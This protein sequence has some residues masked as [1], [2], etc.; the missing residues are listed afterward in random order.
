M[1][2]ARGKNTASCNNVAPNSL[3]TLFIWRLS[4]LLGNKTWNKKLISTFLWL[5]W[6]GLAGVGSWTSCWPGW[7]WVQWP[8]PVLSSLEATGKDY[9][10]SNPSESSSTS[11]WSSKTSPRRPRW[12]AVAEIY[13]WCGTC[14]RL[15]VV[16]RVPFRP[17]RNVP[18]ARETEVWRGL[19]ERRHATRECGRVL[20]SCRCERRPPPSLSTRFRSCV[21]GRRPA[22]TTRSELTYR[23]CLSS[24]VP[25]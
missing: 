19:A 21:D 25:V 16:D 10:C 3:C 11:P 20:W 6:R 8:R 22:T 18:W 5:H 17:R 9:A 13:A 24:E 4:K 15:R 2:A 23:H 7:S 12:S 1:H 14:Q